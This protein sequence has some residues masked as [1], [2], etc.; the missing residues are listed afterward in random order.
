MQFCVTFKNLHF[1]EKPDNRSKS[2]AKHIFRLIFVFVLLYFFV[3]SL[4]LLAN[5]FRLIA[6]KTTGVLSHSWVLSNPIAALMVGILLTVIV[7]SSSTSTSIIITM[8]AAKSEFLPQIL[9]A[10][11]IHRAYGVV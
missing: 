6:G 4:D 8:V 1:Q 10:A 5:S 7:Q 3:C 9:R 11:L 2:I